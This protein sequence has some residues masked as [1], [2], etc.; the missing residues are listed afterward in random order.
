ME[1][2]LKLHKVTKGQQCDDIKNLMYIN[3]GINFSLTKISCLSFTLCLSL[4][5]VTGQRGSDLMV[6]KKIMQSR[7]VHHWM[8][9]STSELSSLLYASMIKMDREW[10]LLFWGKFIEKTLLS[11]SLKVSSSIFKFIEIWDEWVLDGHW[12]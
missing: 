1:A 2:W 11:Y 5:W 6:T 4:S 12:D 3:A 8:P 10:P 7:K 9:G